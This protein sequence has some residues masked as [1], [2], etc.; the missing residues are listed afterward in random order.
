VLV[1]EDKPPKA[2]YSLHIRKR[3]A[4]YFPFAIAVVLP[5]AGF[6]LGAATAAEGDR[7]LGVRLMVIAAL[8]AAI[9]TFLLLA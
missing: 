3:S 9:W 1:G 4:I 7:D 2:P 6:I 8:A 5:P